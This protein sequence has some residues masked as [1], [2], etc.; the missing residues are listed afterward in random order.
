VFVH[1]FSRLTYANVM[2]TVA[3]FVALGGA[4]YAALKL[5]KNSVGTKQLKRSAVTGDKLANGAVTAL[6]VKGRSLTGAQI[7]ASTLGTVPSALRALQAG[8]A[9][10]AAGAD[11]A[12][13]ADHAVAA[14]SAV[15]AAAVG[16][17]PASELLTADRLQSSGII[18]LD[19]LLPGKET[20]LINRGSVSISA[21]CDTGGLNV[22][23]IVIHMASSEPNA[24]AAKPGGPPLL[25]SST[26]QTLTN[27]G[28]T[29][30]S[31]Q[32]MPIAVVTPSTGFHA[33]ITFGTHVGGR[34]CVA[35]AIAAP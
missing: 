32:E 15:N 16:G 30:A 27:A 10:H 6:K 5:P 1:V 26:Q 29:T 12:A 20:T 31:L 11:H 35:G 8:A 28:G 19:A 7:N 9:D 33:S 13:A 17:H 23:N 22:S 21:R 3:L 24:F 18:G 34:D 14:D 2:A 25:L 4:G